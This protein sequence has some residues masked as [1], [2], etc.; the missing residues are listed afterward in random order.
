M[1]EKE[2]AAIEQLSRGNPLVIDSSGSGPGY[3]DFITAH[4]LR[5]RGLVRIERRL[6]HTFAFPV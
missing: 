5:K 4:E 2:K 6:F 3:I 1:S